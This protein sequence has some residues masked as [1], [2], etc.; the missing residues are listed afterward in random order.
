MSQVTY[1]G[2]G[3]L[4]DYFPLLAQITL[5]ANLILGPLLLDAK[6]KLK[7]ALSLTISKPA[8]VVAAKVAASFGVLLPGIVVSAKL[9]AMLNAR[10]KL[11]NGLLTLALQVKGVVP[12]AGFHVA[13]YTGPLSQIGGTIADGSVIASGGGFPLAG[14]NVFAVVLMVDA[15]N[16]ATVTALQTVLGMAPP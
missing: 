16:G 8:I 7:A 11:L 9:V 13:T 14:A 1:V 12:S 6:A 3:A 5:Q 4:S 2:G 15:S 10:L